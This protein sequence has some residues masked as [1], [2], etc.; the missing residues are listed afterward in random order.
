MKVY[1]KDLKEG[2]PAFLKGEITN[3]APMGAFC[4]VTVECLDHGHEYCI[5][6]TKE[7]VAKLLHGKGV[8]VAEP[9]ETMPKYSKPATRSEAGRAGPKIGDR[10][11]I[12]GVLKECIRYDFESQ[13]IPGK[14]RQREPRSGKLGYPVWAVV[15]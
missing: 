9:G 2:L 15:E 6:L 12:K 10:R 13:D 1:A 3:I 11:K 8:V 5:P 7:H 4:I 14:R